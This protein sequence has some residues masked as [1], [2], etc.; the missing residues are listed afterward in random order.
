[1]TVFVVLDSPMKLFC[2]QNSYSSF[3]KQTQK[4]QAG[5]QTDIVYSGPVHFFSI[6]KYVEFCRVVFWI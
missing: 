5:R 4:L 2:A 3:E 1:L 6:T